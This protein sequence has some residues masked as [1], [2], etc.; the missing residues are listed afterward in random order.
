MAG[1]L[2][3]F[4]LGHEC[5]SDMNENTRR[6]VMDAKRLTACLRSLGD[7]YAFRVESQATLEQPSVPNSYETEAWWVR[8]ISHLYQGSPCVRAWVEMPKET[9]EALSGVWSGLE[10]RPIGETL[11]YGNE[12][13]T[14]SAHEYGRSPDHPGWVAR[15]CQYAWKGHAFWIT[16]LFS[17]DMPPFPA[18]AK[19]I[20]RKALWR[21]KLR[22]YAHLIRLHR[23]IPL[24]LMALPT[25]MAL[26][27]A[28]HGF[29]GWR[30]LTVFV[31]GVLVMRSAGDIINDIADRHW[32]GQVQRTA[33]RPL[34]IGR[35]RL[36][37]AWI[38]FGCLMVIALGL[39]LCLNRL[40]VIYACIGLGLACIYPFMK[41]WTSW[42]QLVLGMAYN[43]GMLMAF[44][45]IQ[46]QVPPLAWTAWSATVLW[47][48]A[49]DTQY[50]MADRADD[51]R[52]GIRSTARLFGRFA[53]RWIGVFQ[54]AG[55]L[56]YAGMG[57]QAG[58]GH[59]FALC[60]LLAMVCFIHQH[61]VM[62]Q[63]T[64]EAFIRAFHLNVWP[65]G[66]LF[67][68]VLG[69]FWLG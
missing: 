8:E 20:Q 41:R 5:P 25:L 29:P 2:R 49:Y 30:L 16:E 24:L 6:W 61:R 45:A 11:L 38:A 1:D 57:W 7:A 3:G 14:R 46:N 17:E 47:C 4:E 32:D 10:Q 34:V 54:V 27:I 43:W 39:V 65:Q 28:A 18:R 53:R 19:S 36:R 59:G 64:S 9:V 62:R 35:I 13:V 33:H 66:I 12:S 26:W 44:A 48:I 31:L 22:D 68:G 50:A 37:H 69:T 21:A 56:L 52:I 23:P 55:G 63:E 67:L 60:L 51:E 40:S 58:Y 15:R 42:P